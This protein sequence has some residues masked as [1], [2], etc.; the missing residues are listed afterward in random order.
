M[1]IIVASLLPVILKWP[2]WK[3]PLYGILKIARRFSLRFGFLLATSLS[4]RALFLLP[5]P[6]L[7]AG[8][9]IANM[10]AIL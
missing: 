8:Y 9:N 6:Q 10:K 7:V 5:P 4:R 1:I 2:A 3:A